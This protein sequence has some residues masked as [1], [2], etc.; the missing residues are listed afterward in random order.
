[1]GKLERSPHYGGDN[2]SAEIGVQS[3]PP[4]GFDIAV[5][6]EIKSVS[7]KFK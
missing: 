1:M 5:V 3:Q 6:G 2:A 4:L 7:S